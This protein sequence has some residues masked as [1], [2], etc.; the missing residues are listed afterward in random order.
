[1]PF[2]SPLRRIRT[3]RFRATTLLTFAFMIACQSTPKIEPTVVGAAGSAEGQWRGKAM[4]RDMKNGKNSLLDLD[5][6]AKEPSQLRMEITGSF[7]VHVASVALNGGEVRCILT[8]QKRY[9]EAPAG[10]DSFE[11]LIP[12]HV[13]PAALLA[14]LFERRLSDSEWKCVRDRASGLASSCEHR[15]EGLVVTWVERQ[16]HNRRLK[17][18]AHDAEIEMVLDEAKSKVELT[19]SAFVLAPP[20]GYKIE[21]RTSG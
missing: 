2:A 16:G 14:I 17:I 4:I 5:I 13:P 20:K 9:V 10:V 18:S 7:G 6:L 21:R 11:H 1:M 8:Q 3:E 19:P 12:V 15:G